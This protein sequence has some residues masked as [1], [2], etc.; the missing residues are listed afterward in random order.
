MK[1][2][3][4][5]LLPG[6]VGVSPNSPFS[7]P[8]IGGTRGLTGSEARGDRSIGGQVGDPTLMTCNEIDSIRVVMLESG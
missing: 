3:Q 4:E 6:E 2:V 8:M 7:S 1:E 5:K